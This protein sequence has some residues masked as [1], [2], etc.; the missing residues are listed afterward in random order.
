M[1]QRAL[2]LATRFGGTIQNVPEGEDVERMCAGLRALGFR[3][4]EGPVDGSI[5]EPFERPESPERPERP[6]GSPGDPGVERGVCVVSGGFSRREAEIDAGN[7]GTAARLLL[8]LASLR[9]VWTVIDGSARLRERPVAPLCKALRE[10]GAEVTGD[11]FPVRV[12]GPI[13][14]TTVRISTGI[15]S[16]FAT[17]LIL[18]VPRVK[19][20]RINVSG[21]RSFSYV[22]LTAYVQRGFS[23]PYIV[24]PD[25]SSAAVFAV[26]A[27]TTRGDLLLEGITLSS[28]QGDA[29]V[30]PYL[31]KA[32]ARVTGED[33]G[34]R[35]RGGPLRGFRADVANCPDLA[36][37]LGVMGALA[38][39]ETLLTGAPHLTHKESDRIATTVGLIRALGGKAEPRE[40]GF[41]VTG[42]RRLH[43]GTVSAAG[44][45]RIAMAAAVLALNVPGV[46]V[47]G[48]EAVRKSYP[49]FFGELARLTE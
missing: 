12:K 9:D 33:G 38:T 25:F 7:N 34:L 5:E 1:A 48:A 31:N 41:L 15:S 44:D 10:L 39:G 37:L 23:D 21:R 20:L 49:D 27:A 24:E 22:N 47:T 4:D 17:A 14:G 45:H 36:P 11:A 8:A 46:T 19:G 26:A 6:D 40:D 29:R 43:G 2:I 28:P 3:I 32:G 30:A 42:G 13:R 18:L 16:Q 35:V